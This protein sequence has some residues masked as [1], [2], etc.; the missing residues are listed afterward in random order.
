[1][2]TGVCTWNDERQQGSVVDDEDHY[3]QRV[4]HAISFLTQLGMCIVLTE[5]MGHASIKSDKVN[6][7]CSV[8]TGR[9]KVHVKNEQNKIKS[10]N[11]EG[12]WN[13]KGG[14]GG[15][16]LSTVSS[17]LLFCSD[18]VSTVRPCYTWGRCSRNL[19]HQM[20]NKSRKAESLHLQIDTY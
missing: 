11:E 10:L 4:A 3:L 16:L 19:L 9:W 7:W 18:Y 20:H 12:L 6:I 15:Q 14:I 1:M 5:Y 17:N 2:I 8:K 13:C